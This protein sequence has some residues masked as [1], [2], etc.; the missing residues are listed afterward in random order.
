[1][2]RVRAAIAAPLLA[3]MT[4]F[5]RTPRVNVRE[6]G[7]LGYEYVIFPVS[8]FRVASRAMSNLYQ[9]LAARGD[10]SEMESAMMPRAELYERIKY[11]EFESL[12]HKI[13]ATVL[14]S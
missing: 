9:S 6:W 8:A 14:P 3:N 7:Q 4:E 13:A 5:G 11:Y 2:E 12:D 10:V 1:M